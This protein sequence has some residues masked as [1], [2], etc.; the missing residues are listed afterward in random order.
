MREAKLSLIITPRK[1]EAFPNEGNWEK[2]PTE[3]FA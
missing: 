1:L 2:K 3:I